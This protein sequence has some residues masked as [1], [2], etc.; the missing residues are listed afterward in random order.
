MPDVRCACAALHLRTGSS[1]SSLNDRAHRQTRIVHL[2][3]PITRQ[4]RPSRQHRSE[5]VRGHR[6]P[7]HCAQSS[8][9]PTPG[10]AAGGCSV[11]T[12]AL[13]PPAVGRFVLEVFLVRRPSAQHSGSAQCRQRHRDRR[14]RRLRRVGRPQAHLTSRRPLNAQLRSTESLRVGPAHS[15][16]LRGRPRAVRRSSASRVSLSPPRSH[17][18]APNPACSG[19]RFAR[20]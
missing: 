19:R 15:P 12:G 3:I 6:G 1:F 11:F 2:G 5:L 13:A 17:S 18:V 20:R 8:G 16:H 9:G 10:F 4:P 7:R 14:T